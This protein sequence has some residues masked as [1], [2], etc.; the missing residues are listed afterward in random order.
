M[1]VGALGF[2][3]VFTVFKLRMTR[4]RRRGVPNEENPQMEWDDSGLN[5]I[6]NP[7]D[8]EAN[9]IFDLNE[10]KIDFLK[11]LIGRICQK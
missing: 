6:E 7:M 2:L 9:V 11:L 5:I 4:H 3:I 8:I 10:F 1:S